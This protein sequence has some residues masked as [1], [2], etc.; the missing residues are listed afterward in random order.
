MTEPGIRKNVGVLSDK[1]QY[2][3]YCATKTNLYLKGFRID[4][5]PNTVITMA[6][7]VTREDFSPQ[8]ILKIHCLGSL[9]KE[10]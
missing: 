5:E 8:A 9:D 7:A 6:A 1:G 3:N 4:P 10:Y 2:D